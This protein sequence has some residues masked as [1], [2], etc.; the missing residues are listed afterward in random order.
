MGVLNFLN[1]GIMGVLKFILSVCPLN[2]GPS[3][4]ASAEGYLTVCKKT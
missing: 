4:D 3:I 2:F 1:A